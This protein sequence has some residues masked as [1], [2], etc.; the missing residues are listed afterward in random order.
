MF[1]FKKYSNVNIK[2]YHFGSHLK[3]STWLSQ[4]FI[5]FHTHNSF[6]K[7][8]FCYCPHITGEE[9]KDA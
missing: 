5:S 2:L 3:I 6:I 8:G 7:R 1:Y 4:D 9:A